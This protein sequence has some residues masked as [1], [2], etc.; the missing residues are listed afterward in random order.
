MEC[1]EVKEERDCL[2]QKLQELHFDLQFEKKRA[3]DLRSCVAKATQ[4]SSQ[5]KQKLKQYETQIK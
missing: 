5:D 2:A 4:E 1:S 3:Q